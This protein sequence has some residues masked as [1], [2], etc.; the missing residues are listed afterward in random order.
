MPIDIPVLEFY[1]DENDNTDVGGWS[2]KWAGYRICFTS[3]YG[4]P[5]KPFIYMDRIKGDDDENATIYPDGR[6]ELG[7]YGAATSFKDILACISIRKALKLL[8]SL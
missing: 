3:E 2:A 4:N 6:I 1:K 7:A 8:K 5:E